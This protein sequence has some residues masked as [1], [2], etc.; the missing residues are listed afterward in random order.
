MW[1]AFGF[2]FIN[3]YFI[4]GLVLGC[5]YAL[6]AIGITLTFG[7]LRFANFAH[8][9]VMMSGAYLTWTVM[10][11]ITSV[12]GIAVHPLVAA[13]PAGLIVIWLFLLTDK[14]FYKPF[15]KADTIKVVMASFGMMLIIRSAVQ[16][17]WGPNQLTFVQGI[18]KPNTVLQSFSQSIDML[19]LIPNKHLFIF[20][21]T[22]VI[23]IALSYLLNR[24][25]IGKAMRAVS[26][27]PD[28][29][30][31]T[32]ID[33]DQV[34]RATW[35]VGG[36]CAMAA[37]VFLAMDIQM[38]ETTMGFR[39]LLPMFAAAILGGIGKPYGA[40]FGGLVIGLAEELSAYPW[41]G[42]AP[43][44]SPGYKTGV[45]FAIMVI[46]LIVRPQGLFKGRSF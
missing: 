44:I 42:D 24:T 11:I 32:G 13:V 34:I 4:P 3:F 38:L 1:D 10:A 39:M 19:L 40:V 22:I 20:T 12:L 16:V 25:R 23:V 37:G 21:G 27:S 14:Y 8:G 28:L 7:I 17:I 36:A 35:I 15:R 2:E 30:H 31:V 26:D 29:A 45:A 33:V 9:E 18:A 41:I 43:L 6:G 5:I 46:M